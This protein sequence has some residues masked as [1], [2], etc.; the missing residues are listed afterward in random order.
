MGRCPVSCRSLRWRLSATVSPP[1]ITHAAWGI[2]EVKG[3]RLEHGG[4]EV[5]N[6]CAPLAEWSA[7]DRKCHVRSYRPLPYQHVIPAAPGSTP[8]SKVR[9]AYTGRAPFGQS[10]R[11]QSVCSVENVKDPGYGVPPTPG[12]GVGRYV[13]VSGK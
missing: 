5:E 11:L 12:G 4:V 7:L 2:L 1:N 8:A 9:G 6:T 10:M 3:V 13:Y